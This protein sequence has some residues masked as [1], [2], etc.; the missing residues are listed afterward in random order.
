M[1]WLLGSPSLLN[2]AAKRA[3]LHLR[4]ESVIDNAGAG[5]LSLLAVRG[6]IIDGLCE[7]LGEILLL[8]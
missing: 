7:A 2:L 6:S 5:E 4:L 8:R 3:W 1:D